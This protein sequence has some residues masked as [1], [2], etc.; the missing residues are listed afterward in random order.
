M[1]TIYEKK[2]QNK[3][4]KKKKEHTKEDRERDKEKECPKDKEGREVKEKRKKEN[5]EVC[6]R[7]LKPLNLEKEKETF[8]TLEGKYDPF[9]L[10][11]NNNPLT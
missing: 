7:E 3:S 1:K 2:A 11:N 6:L 10:Y 5:Y 8:F 4:K 9:F